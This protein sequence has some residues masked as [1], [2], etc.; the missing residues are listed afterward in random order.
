MPSLED[1]EKI[2]NPKVCSK[3]GKRYNPKIHSKS[4]PHNLSEKFIR[5]Q[6]EYID[7]YVQ[8]I[9]RASNRPSNSKLRYK[10]VQGE[11]IK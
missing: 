5:E 9:E 11:M 8:E 7:K 2:R 6:R 4:C 3:C 1:L 10:E